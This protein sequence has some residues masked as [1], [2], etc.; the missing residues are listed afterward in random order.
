MLAFAVLYFA[1]FGDQREEL[2][3][4]GDASAARRGLDLDFD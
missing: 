4:K 3:G 1:V 2:V